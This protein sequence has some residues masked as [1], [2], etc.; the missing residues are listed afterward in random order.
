MA[1]G[2]ARRYAA[3]VGATG[4]AA[5]AGYVGYVL[6][7]RFDLPAAT[8]ASLLALAAAAGIA[9]FFSPCSF[10]LAVTLLARDTMPPATGAVNALEPLAWAGGA[11]FPSPCRCAHR[12]RS[13]FLFQASDIHE[14]AWDSDPRHRRF[15][16][17]A[18]RLDPAQRPT[19]VVARGR[20]R[21][22]AV[23]GAPGPPQARSA[24]A[25]VRIVGFGYLLAGFG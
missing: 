6:Y 20:R 9:S 16:A 2:A 15:A 25:G 8:G 13:R 14:H 18:S 21:G 7:P 10:P 11:A 24:C 3:L 23:A 1:A 17:C 4:A 5:V 19:R 22:E 12:S